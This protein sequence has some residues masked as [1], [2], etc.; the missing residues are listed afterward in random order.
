MLQSIMQSARE[1]ERDD[2]DEERMR[3][4]SPRPVTN[5]GDPAETRRDG[6][7]DVSWESKLKDEFSIVSTATEVQGQE[8]MMIMTH[9][10]LT[11]QGES[12]ETW[13]K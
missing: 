3:P 12:T 11:V 5:R 6:R 2:H 10:N 8:M 7:T 4:R 1:S 13:T 9:V